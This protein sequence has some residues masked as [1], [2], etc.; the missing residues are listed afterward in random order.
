MKGT[1]SKG[2]EITTYDPSATGYGQIG[3]GEMVGDAVL[4][5]TTFA[6]ETIV[7]LCNYLRI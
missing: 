6:G 4:S 3:P 7:R 5:Y 1:G 2:L